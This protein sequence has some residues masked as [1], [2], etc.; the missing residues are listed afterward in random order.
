[1]YTTTGEH[2]SPLSR[3]SL[4]WYA[5][6]V[7]ANAEVSAADDLTHL[8][9]DV[10]LPTYSERRKYCDRV[11]SVEIAIFPG[12]IFCRFHINQKVGIISSS[13]VQ[14]IV[15][16]AGV[17]TPICE[18]EISNVRR[19]VEAG[20][21]PTPYVSIGRRVRIS[22]GAL[23]GIEGFV[24]REGSHDCFVVSVDLLSRSVSLLLDKAQL[25]LTN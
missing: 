11:K 10:Y 15:G 3:T 8:G 5:V 9:C 16:M 7:R 13:R 20:G 25:T 6:R 21:R 22:S 14:Y 18:E 24:I 12:Y 2:S 23:S 4:C 17:P 1:M 19:L